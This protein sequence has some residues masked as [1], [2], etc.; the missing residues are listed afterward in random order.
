MRK[1]HLSHRRFPKYETRL[2]YALYPRLFCSKKT[3]YYLY[4]TD[5]VSFSI[6]HYCNKENVSCYSE[7]SFLA[8]YIKYCLCVKNS[9]AEMNCNRNQKLALS[10]FIVNELRF[11]I[12]NGI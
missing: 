12:D 2:R 1:M 3:F 8:A 7:I 9:N 10:T 4:V 11:R 6:K 5:R